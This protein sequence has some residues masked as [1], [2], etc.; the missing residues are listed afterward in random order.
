LTRSGTRWHSRTFSTRSIGRRR[1]R[2]SF[3]ST[4]PTS[5]PNRRTG[6]TI[7]DSEPDVDRRVSI[8]P[9]LATCDDC[10][11][12]IFDRS[13]RRYRYAF[14]NCTN[15][16]PRFTIATDI[17]YDRR[18]TTMARFEMCPACRREYTDVS[19][20]RFHAQP[21]ACPA[22][23]PQLDLRAPDGARLHADDVIAVA[24][25]AIR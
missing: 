8:P 10:L 20:R 7:V 5:R 21:N 23:G 12:E 18:A 22:C 19:D 4:S 9:D 11:S 16:G 25:R 2:G 1:R 14:T 3:A 6:S 15:C 24:A 17:P 13:N